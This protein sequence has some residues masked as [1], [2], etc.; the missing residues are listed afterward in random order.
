MGDLWVGLTILA[1]ASVA[2][3]QSVRLIAVALTPRTRLISTAAV[4]ALLAIFLTF[5]QSPRMATLFPVSNLIVLSNWLPILAAAAAALLWTD[6][7]TATGRRHALA[8]FALALGCWTAINPLMGSV[9]QCRD[10]VGPYGDTQQST[11][12]TCSAASAATFLRAHGIEATEQEMA[13]LCLTRRGT[14]WMGIYRGLVLKTKG[15]RWKVEMVSDRLLAM[16]SVGRRPVLANMGLTRARA[17]VGNSSVDRQENGWI[18]GVDHTVV[19][20]GRGPGNTFQVVDPTPGIDRE[21]WRPETFNT[22]WRGVG[23]QLVER[24]EPGISVIAKNFETD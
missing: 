20:L 7:Q 11:E 16:Q 5:W 3:F 12:F 22:L 14:S 15:T 13:E 4:V 24:D 1:L 10:R 8:C 23:F 18:P 9:P 19:F 2:T 21:L 17:L 6:T